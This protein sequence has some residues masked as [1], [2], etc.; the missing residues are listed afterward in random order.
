MGEERVS[1]GSVKGAQPQCPISNFFFWG[2]VPTTY[3]HDMTNSDQI[4]QCDLSLFL[5]FNSHFPGESGL[6]GVH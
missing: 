6:A 5:H 3:S 4:L 1:T 2:G